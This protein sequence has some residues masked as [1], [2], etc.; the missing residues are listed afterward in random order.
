MKWS[1][2][3]QSCP[4]LCDPMDCSPPGSSVHGILQ[5]RLLEW[6]AISFSKGSFLPRD[7]T[8][9][10][11]IAG[12]CF[13]LWATK[14][15]LNTYLDIVVQSLSCVQF[16]V[17]PWTAAHQASLSFAISQRLLKL[18]SIELLILSN[19]L[20]CLPLLLLPSVFPSI[21]DFSNESALRIR[22]PKYWSVSFSISPSNE[23]LGFFFFL[24]ID[25]FDLA[26][27]GTL[28]SLLQHHNSK[29]SILWCPVF[30]MVQI[31]HP[32]TWLLEKP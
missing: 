11:H 2:V 6:V 12:R 5:T 19:H 23:Y 27:Q 8:Q 14:E 18:R 24:W 25:W 21:R 22:W 15:Q 17:T 30:F 26:V 9:V 7:R 31:L 1:E 32:Y 3:A 29:A 28:K 10:S 13:N 20:I 4:T 16:F